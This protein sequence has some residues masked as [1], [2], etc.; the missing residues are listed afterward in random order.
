M[1]I[2]GV[3]T[4]LFW[5]FGLGW[6]DQIYEGLPAINLAFAFGWFVSKRVD[7]PA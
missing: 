4:A 2:G 7:T 6:H 1:L 5:R 3:S